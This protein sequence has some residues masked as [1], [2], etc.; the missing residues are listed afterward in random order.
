MRKA[1]VMQAFRVTLFILSKL[2]STSVSEC[3]LPLGLGFT[4]A[5]SKVW[6]N[7][8]EERRAIAANRFIQV[9]LG[10][11]REVSSG[12]RFFCDGCYTTLSIRKRLKEIWRILMRNT[13]AGV[14]LLAAF[15]LFSASAFAANVTIST[16]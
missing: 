11:E 13:P 12:R 3:P 6:P 8:A 9:L 1:Q 5:T 2:P 7:S 15:A 10:I 16:G 4:E 14:R